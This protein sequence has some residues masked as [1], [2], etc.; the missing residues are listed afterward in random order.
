MVNF[1]YI[2]SEALLLWAFYILTY[3]KENITS[4]YSLLNSV[5]SFPVNRICYWLQVVFMILG[6]VWSTMA[7][8]HFQQFVTK[9]NLFI[10]YTK[11]CIASYCIIIFIVIMHHFTIGKCS[12]LERLMNRHHHTLGLNI[13]SF[14]IV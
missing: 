6:K 5:G 10:P 3:F 4:I 14:G 1:G 8:M 12:T 7:Y 2:S 11:I 9:R 13:I